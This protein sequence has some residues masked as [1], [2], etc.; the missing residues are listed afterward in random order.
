M[1]QRRKYLGVVGGGYDDPIETDRFKVVIPSN[2][3]LRHDRVIARWTIVKVDTQVWDDE[4]KGYKFEMK[5]L[6][7][8]EDVN[9]IPAH[10]FE[11]S[12]Q[13]AHSDYY[14]DAEFCAVFSSTAEDAVTLIV[15]SIGHITKDGRDLYGPVRPP[16]RESPVY[17]AEPDEVQMAVMKPMNLQ[18]GAFTIGGYATLDGL[19]SPFTRQMLP[20]HQV[21][22]HGAIFAASGWGKTMAIKHFLREFHNLNPS[23]AIVVF[24]IKGSEFY[25]L[26]KALPDDEYRKLR[27]RNPDAEEI[28]KELS[29]SPAGFDPQRV[30]YYPMGVDIR[31]VGKVYSLS[32]SQIDPNEEG[33]A[34]LRFIMEPFNLFEAS[35]NYLTEY[36]FFC[37]RH[38]TNR[39][40]QEVHHDCA[41]AS[42]RRGNSPYNVPFND[43]FQSFVGL[44]RE[45]IRV[46]GVQAPVVINCSICGDSIFI[47]SSVAGAINRAL[48]ELQRLSVFDVG[49]AI[50]IRDL[51]RP[52]HISVVDVAGLQS[53]L[54]QQIF[55]QYILHQIFRRANQIFLEARADEPYEG[56]VIFLDEAWRFFRTSSVLDE[57]ETIS[58]MGRSLRVG[59]WL[60][61]QNIPTGEREWNVLNNIR[62]RIIG[63]ISADRAILKRVMP[64]EETMLAVLP[65]LRRGMAI[66]FNQEYSRIPTPVIIP[67]CTCYHEGD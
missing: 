31:N 45:A 40:S 48:S 16:E 62:T 25:N 3:P 36:L 55:V 37:K 1:A 54:A 27:E 51:M 19:Y 38:F 57:L 64:L 33:Q 66:F 26:E 67:P 13:M 61:D 52:G 5:T 65:N 60:A 50:N 32:F 2:A 20:I 63:S 21:F 56:V 18:R 11:D 41:Q 14:A 9:I 44:L 29:L 34:F 59:L 15:R 47:P 53:G 49:Q 28:L 10:A 17:V 35:M 24:N 22:L 46:A 4:M 58:R 43:T 30:T 42:L 6:G 23:P 7:I 8:V 39:A 12:R